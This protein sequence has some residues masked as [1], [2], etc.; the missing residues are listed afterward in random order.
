MGDEELSNN[1]CRNCGTET[2]ALHWPEDD[3]RCP[4]IKCPLH[5][6]EVNSLHYKKIF[7]NSIN[8]HAQEVGEKNHE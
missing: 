8:Q 6:L 1:F 7:N 2:E 4:D 5:D 3:Y